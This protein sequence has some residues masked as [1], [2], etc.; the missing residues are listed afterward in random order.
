MYTKEEEEYLKSLTP[1]EYKAYEI[2]KNHLG[3]LFT[4]HKT[5]GFLLWKK[6]N[7]SKK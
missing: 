5:A 7:E 6:K 2:A 1:K 3:S 4:L